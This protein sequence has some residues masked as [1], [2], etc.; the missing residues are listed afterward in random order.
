MPANPSELLTS[1]QVAALLGVTPMTVVRWSDNGLLPSERTP[2]HHRRFR[3]DAVEALRNQAG[4]VSDADAW[5]NLLRR[6]VAPAAVEA[7][8]FEDHAQKSSWARVADGLGPV[9]ERLGEQWCKG[10]LTVFEE[11]VASAQLS[12]G[13]ARISAWLPR[14]PNA[15]RALLAT[16]DGEQ[17]TLGLALAELCLREQ[18][19][20]TVWAGASVPTR[21]L[22][23][24]LGGG[25]FG[26][27]VLSASRALRIK[28][29][30]GEQIKAVEKA[31]VQNGSEL[32][33]GGEA[34]WPALSSSV[35]RFHS[36]T[37]FS[38][39]LAI[40]R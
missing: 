13:L 32:V 19:W 15:P 3:R 40:R 14:R 21:E 8:L 10:E 11:H 23:R 9:L 25:G 38:E 34:A 26:V 37:A 6:P 31:C 33:L 2:G 5:V 12:R 39:Y 28:P 22:Q 27:V 35:R 36:F 20:E 4:N 1:S 18:A 30:L 24:E 16:P 17:H 7:K 29:A